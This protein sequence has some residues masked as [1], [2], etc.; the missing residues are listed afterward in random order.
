MDFKQLKKFNG[1]KKREFAARE[2]AIEVNRKSIVEKY[3]ALEGKDPQALAERARQ[4]IAAQTDMLRA[5]LDAPTDGTIFS[6]VQA[7]D[8]SVPGLLGEGRDLSRNINIPELGSYV[9]TS[10]VAEGDKNPRGSEYHLNMRLG[11]DEPDDTGND[12]LHVAGAHTHFNGQ[13]DSIFASHN[14][15]NGGPNTVNTNAEFTSRSTLRANEVAALE[16]VVETLGVICEA[17]QVE[18][19]PVQ[20][21]A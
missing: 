10:F 7:E 14:T 12:E 18:V 4:L 6:A 2:E 8:S 15:V 11:E 3:K 13:T 9:L 21:S 20:A 16:E 5:L 17:A 1:S 19:N